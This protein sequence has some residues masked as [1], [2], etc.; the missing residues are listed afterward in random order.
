MKVLTVKHGQDITEIHMLNPGE[1]Y[2]DFGGS[3][4]GLV[5]GKT[6]SLVLSRR[7]IMGIHDTELDIYDKNVW[8]WIARLINDNGGAVTAETSK[9]ETNDG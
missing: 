4:S 2:P 5:V 7:G 1:H 6:A 3:R 9:E 8:A